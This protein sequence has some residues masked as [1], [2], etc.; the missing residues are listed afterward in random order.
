MIMLM[1]D[2][3]IVFCLTLLGLVLGSFAGA[4]V[5]RMRAWQLT[6]DR[7]RLNEL[8]AKKKSSLSDDE[9]EE[10]ADLI[11]SKKEMTAELKTLNSLAERKVSNDR[12]ECL[13]CHKQLAWYDMIPLASWL[14][15][16]GKC[17]YCKK[18]IGVFEPLIEIGM[19]L[20]LVILYIFWPHPLDSTPAVL[21]LLA[22][23]A[24]ALILIILFAYDLKWFL[25]PNVPVF[26]FIGLSFMVSSLHIYQAQS[27]EGALTSVAGSVAILSGVYALLWYVSKGAWIGFGDVK[28]GLG[29]AL[30]LSDWQLAFIAL[31]LANFIGCIVVF[32]GMLAGKI[33]RTT[34]IPFG[35]LLII[36]TFIALFAGHSIIDWYSNL[37]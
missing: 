26:I 1:D 25:L 28:L 6:G 19:A 11:A 27:F 22:W 12:S 30:L 20:A 23:M 24:S 34:R 9:Q 13:H 7:D 32:P 2:I 18:S 36:G 15:T 5:W 33:S 29:L 35:P 31:F 3:F 4:T 16:G 14:S 21:E 10:L 17:R 37:L 8:S